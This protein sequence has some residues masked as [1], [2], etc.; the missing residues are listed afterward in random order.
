MS[1]T[2]DSYGSLE[3]VDC[4]WFIQI[5]TYSLIW[6]E[7]WM[8]IMSFFESLFMHSWLIHNFFYSF[9]MN[10]L[11][12]SLSMSHCS[13]LCIHP[14]INPSI[15]YQAWISDFHSYHSLIPFY[16]FLLVPFIM[17][18]HTFWVRGGRSRSSTWPC[19]PWRS[20]GCR[21][22]AWRASGHTSGSGTCASWG[23]CP[24]PC[25]WPPPCLGQRCRLLGVRLARQA[26]LCIYIYI[27]IIYI[28]IYIYLI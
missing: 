18:H 8:W 16:A 5:G 22:R 9:R 25:P 28:Y 7:S 12:R 11:C 17:N 14:C 10:H 13:P 20:W 4:T 1:L 24:C 19:R 3:N 26:G 15:I 27:C 6:N 21:R 23:S 2:L